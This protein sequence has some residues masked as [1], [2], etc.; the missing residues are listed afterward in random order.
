MAGM[1][2]GW[3]GDEISDLYSILLFSQFRYKKELV[4]GQ[5][6]IVSV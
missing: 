1:I 2:W 3:N 5:A 4:P 6:G